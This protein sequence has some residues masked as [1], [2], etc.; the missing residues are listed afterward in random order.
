MD[1]S[2]VAPADSSG[3]EAAGDTQGETPTRELLAYSLPE[4]ANVFVN[5]ASTNLL[6]P[7]LVTGLHVSPALVG[8]ALM[9]RGLWDAATD[10]V[11]GHVS[12][13]T[14]TRFGRRR[15]Y[16]ALGGI[17]MAIVLLAMWAFPRGSSEIHI[18]WHIGICLVLFATAQTIFSVPYGALALELSSTYNG[19]TRVQLVKTYFSRVP[20]FVSP[21]FVS[22]CFASWFVDAL[23][24]IRWM[25][26]F[27]AGFIL[28]ASLVAFFGTKE[29]AKVSAT[30]EKFWHAIGT[31]LRSVHFL[32]IA[33][34]YVAL[35][36]T[37][38]AFGA[39]SYFLTVYY[40]FG[41]DVARGTLFS[42]HVELF[43]GV[44]V[45]AGVP[46]VGWASKRFQ[47][48]NALRIAL[49]LMIIGSALQLVLL[50]PQRP[51]LMFISPFFYS[52]GIASTFVIL[53]TM[54]ADVID[55]DE[56]AT[57]QRREG[58]FG[59]VAAFM[60]KSMGAVAAGASGFLISW[61]GFDAELGG[62]Q[63]PG[64]F[65]NMLWMFAGK[66]LLLAACLLVLYR[67]PLTEQRVAEIQKLLA[68]RKKTTA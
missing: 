32:K 18:A 4:S 33:F 44:L 68:I 23:A 6:H 8:T 21:Y 20:G 30:K 22:F 34:I 55:A 28:L 63:A 29:R 45:L 54:L 13:N 48:H 53:G 66:G 60:M 24:G 25:A 50:D 17:L 10:P 49:V 3:A 37:L 36:F 2:P 27:A 14:R 51:W 39:F 16:I 62:A 41:G 42:G 1:T 59:A 67:Y 57:G 52:M 64:V 12:D 31:T 11:M 38:G 26:T 9:V 46:L 35:L 7:I 43:A 19:R 65:H 5:A 58:L 40:V 61:T 47:K 15:P 56:L